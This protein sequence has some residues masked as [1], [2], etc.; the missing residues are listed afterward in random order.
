L[1]G[2]VTGTVTNPTVTV[3]HSL[4]INNIIVTFTGTSLTSVINNINSAN[5]PGVTAEAV[6][7]KLKIISDVV[8]A[9]N[10]LTIVNGNSGGTALFDLG[11]QQYKYVQII[12][13]PESTGE[14]FGTALSVDQTPNT[15]VIGSNGADVAIPTTFD[16]EQGSATTF[17]GTG[18]KFVQLIL[19]AGGVYN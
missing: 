14:I 6:N 10:K 1:Y 4:S 5:I 7:N 9:A 11:I 18:T 13:H 16:F 8:V 15:L 3:G 17:D 12:K 2:V 19:D